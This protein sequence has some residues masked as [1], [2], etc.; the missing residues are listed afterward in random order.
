MATADELCRQANEKYV[1][2][3]Y[4]RAVE[5]YS[6]ALSKDNERDDIYCH[7]A[8]AN[9]KL[10]NLSD[11]A[12]DCDKAIHLNDKNSKAYIRKGTALF[13]MDEIGKA[14]DVFKEGKSMSDSDGTFT[15]WIAKCEDRIS[16][17]PA[18][19]VP[20]PSIK[21]EW[22]QTH[23][24]VVI[25]VF[26]KKVKKENLV[27]DVEER[28]VK[29]QIKEPSFDLDLLLFH[30][31]VPQESLTKIMS[32]KI[33]VKLKK[34]EGIQWSKLEGSPEEQV[35]VPF[36][37]AL[38]SEDV[39]KYPTSSHYTRDWDKLAKDVTEEEKNEKLE[40]DAGLNKFFQNLYGD[41]SDETKRAMMKSFSES[42][43]TVLSTNW[44]EVGAKKVEVKPP[45]G[46]EYKQWQQ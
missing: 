31:V 41:A 9:L 15:D 24:H 40:G 20:K 6:E 19:A 17:S 46:M 44:S 25:T 2:E 28:K 7:R 37:T 22:Y 30:H 4:Q 29:I 26:A 18:T 43:G 13:Q 35:T 36:A 12:L 8:Q 38:P 27:V 32:T 39:P 23:T 5:L 11:A 34:T 1:D 33:E 14:L 42:G 3:D 21:H 45:D 10:G 16:M